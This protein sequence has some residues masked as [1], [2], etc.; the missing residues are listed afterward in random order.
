MGCSGSEVGGNSPL[1]K[2]KSPKREKDGSITNSLR[3]LSS[4]FSY[5]NNS[6]INA[7]K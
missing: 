2:P 7:H 1:I 4:N 3:S 6:Y 5:N